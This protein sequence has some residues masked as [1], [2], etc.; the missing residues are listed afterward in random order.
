MDHN[1]SNPALQVIDTSLSGL[2]PIYTADTELVTH[3][4]FLNNGTKMG[5]APSN[6][7]PRILRC[8]SVGPMFPSPFVSF[9]V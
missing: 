7:A 1:S 4:I 6:T 8:L 3:D 5:K 9:M 2:V